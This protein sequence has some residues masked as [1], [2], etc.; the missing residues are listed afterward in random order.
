MSS[1]KYL[2]FG[3]MRLPLLDQNDPTSQDIPQVCRMVDRFLEAGFT[4]FDTAFAYPGSEEAIRKALVERHNRASYT[5]TNKMPVFLIHDRETIAA[6]FEESR[7]RCGVEYFDYYLL[8][9]ISRKTWP[10]VLEYDCIEAAKKLKADGKVWEIGFSFH[11]RAE[12]LD[13][14]L[15][16]HPEFDFVQLMVNYA[17]WDSAVVESGKCYKVACRHGKPVVIMEPLRGGTLANLPEYA[18]KALREKGIYASQASLALR[19]AAGLRNVRVVLSGMSSMEQMEQN[20]ETFSKLQPLNEKEQSALQEVVDVL[21][22][23]YPLPAVTQESF[24]GICPLDIA[25]PEYFEVYNTEQYEFNAG[26]GANMDYFSTLLKFR[27]K[28]SDCDGCGKCS[29]ICSQDIPELL[30][31]KILPIQLQAE[32]MEKMFT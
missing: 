17:D 5:L 27:G 6:T 4:Y 10:T 2:G 24:A 1:S 25:V 18:A 26:T 31:E 19:F 16:G 32:E 22:A 13:E 29:G 12:M 7:K 9:D 3:L 21:K 15:T 11:D 30:R 20:I 23:Q 8:H 28:P 14:I